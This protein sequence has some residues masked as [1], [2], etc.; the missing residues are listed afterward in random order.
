MNP[1]MEYFH[2]Y[3]VGGHCALSRDDYPIS[4]A[5]VSP[6][7]SHSF[8][9]PGRCLALVAYQLGVSLSQCPVQRTTLASLKTS[10]SL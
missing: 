8:L 3:W 4:G 2:F 7:V 5:R 9:R 10:S 1:M 6:T